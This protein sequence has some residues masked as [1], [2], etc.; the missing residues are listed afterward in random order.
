MQEKSTQTLTIMFSNYK[1]NNYPKN[2]SVFQ[3]WLLSGKT[4][5][6][7][8]GKGR[9]FRRKTSKFWDLWVLPPLVDQVYDVVYV[10]GIHLGSKA[11]VLI[12]C[13]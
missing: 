9:T 6:D 13:S 8:P 12:A 11:V 5:K 7:M 4:F 3:D 1:I 10:D 2:L